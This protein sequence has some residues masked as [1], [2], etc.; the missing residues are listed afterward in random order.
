MKIVTNSEVKKPYDCRERAFDFALYDGPSRVPPVLIPAPLIRVYSNLSSYSRPAG[1]S[2]PHGLQHPEQRGGDA[3][4]RPEDADGPDLLPGD[5]DLGPGPCRVRKQHQQTPVFG[6][7]LIQLLGRDAGSVDL[8][9]TVPDTITKWAAGA[10]CVSPGG[11]GVAPSAALT[12]FQPFFVSLTLPY[13]VVRGEV[14]AL[15]ATVF[16]YLSD[17]L[18]VSAAAAAIFVFGDLMAI[19]SLSSSSCRSRSRW[20]TRTSTPTGAARAASTRRVCAARRA[21]PSPGS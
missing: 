20:R 4:G 2:S 7:N 21:A 9:R 14:L 17:C 16:N 6:S 3:E 1:L 18:M 12:A 10:F 19:G 13:S 11:F 5:V 15:R 8:D